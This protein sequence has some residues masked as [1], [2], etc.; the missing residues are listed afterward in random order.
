MHLLRQRKLDEDIL[1]QTKNMLSVIANK[2]MVQDRKSGKVTTLKD[3]HNIAQNNNKS[4]ND[5]Q[6]L[7]EEMRKVDVKIISTLSSNTILNC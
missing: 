3:Q 7:L 6:A 4:I 2:E 5:A 1:E